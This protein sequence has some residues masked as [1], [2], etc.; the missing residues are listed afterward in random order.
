MK[1]IFD[2]EDLSVSWRA[3]SNTSENDWGEVYSSLHQ[4]THTHTHTH[5]QAHIHTHHH[6]IHSSPYPKNTPDILWWVIEWKGLHRK[7]WRLSD[8]ILD[9]C[10]LGPLFY[11]PSSFTHW[12]S[13]VFFKVPH[14]N[15]GDYFLHAWHALLMF[16]YFPLALIFY[17]NLWHDERFMAWHYQLHMF[18]MARIGEM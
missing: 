12:L 7:V 10:C 4:N 5:A 2:A 15:M 17:L 6:L 8:L 3:Q 14:N 16:S 13:L 9:A 1:W 11:L 18:S